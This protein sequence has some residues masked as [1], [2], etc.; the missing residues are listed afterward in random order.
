MLALVSLPAMTRRRQEQLAEFNER[1]EPGDNK[2]H[3]AL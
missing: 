2:S 3:A 1:L